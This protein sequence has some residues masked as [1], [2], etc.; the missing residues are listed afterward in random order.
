MIDFLEDCG[1]SEEE[2]LEL[3]LVE[4]LCEERGE[5]VGV[6]F[7]VNCDVLVG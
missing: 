6:V 7:L 1:E 4:S 5:L 2:D 3:V